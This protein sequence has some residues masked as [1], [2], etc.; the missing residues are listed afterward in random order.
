MEW[1]GRYPI[2][3]MY[4]LQWHIAVPF[5]IFYCMLPLISFFFFCRSCK[6]PFRWGYGGCYMLLSVAVSI[7]EKNRHLQGSPG[8]VAEILLLACCGYVLLK[9]TWMESLTMSVLILSVLSVCNGI[10]DWIGYR[11]I[12][13]FLLGHQIWVLPSDAVR[14]CIRLVLVCGLFVWILHYF[15]RSIAKTNRQTLIHLTL[16]VFFISLVVR[17]IQTSVYGDNVTV[18]SETGEI[19]TALNINHAE[20]LFLQLFACVCLLAVLSAYQ[21]ILGILQAEQR[22]RLL[23]Q[24]AAKQEIYM[25]EAILRDRQTRAFRHDI[26]NHLT[27]LAEL[28]GTGQ[29]ER[30][31]DYLSDLEETA[32][33][34][35]RLIWTGNAAVDALLGSKLS[36]A[37]QKNIEVNCEMQ[38]PGCSGIRDVDWCI[39][40]ANALDNAIKACEEMSE[41]RKYI[42]MTSQQKG[43]LCLLTIENSCDRRMKE[44]PG[45]GIGLSNIRAVMERH[46]GVVENTV[47]DGVY[48]LKL[49]FGSLQQK[50]DV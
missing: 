14:E 4:D 3:F 28:L 18:N 7:W 40:L 24:Q 38:I 39:L 23:E 16:P 6:V 32:S 50:N 22:L 9:R 31:S 5:L 43:S 20:L 27:V 42:S 21:K 46:H 48:C 2:S 49:F 35:S 19:L 11:I 8:L 45:D 25:Q 15:R 17:I 41:G 12:L 13:P 30:A 29:S 47:H 26:R 33:G 44:P 37:G 36:V 34:L 1:A 10:T